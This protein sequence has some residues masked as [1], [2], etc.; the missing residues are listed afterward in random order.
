M[1]RFFLGNQVVSLLFLPLVIAGYLLLN[2]GVFGIET[3][4]FELTKFVDLGLWGRL[5][6]PDLQWMKWLSGCLVL[7]NAL[8]LNL[9][10]NNNAFYER[11]SYIVSL[12]YIVLMSFYHSFYQVDGVLIAHFW[13][14]LLL[15]QL[16]KMESNQD[17]RRIAFNAGLFF[18]LA[19][20]FHPPLIFAVPLLWIMLTRIRPFVFREILLS[21]AGFLVPMIYGFMV[22]FWNEKQINWNFIETAINYSQKQFIF[23]SFFVLFSISAVLS[24][25]GMRIKNS[26]SSIRFRKLTAIIFVFLLIGIALGTVEII[27]LKQYEWFS[28]SMLSLALFLPFS[29]F[30]KSTHVFATLLFYVTLIFS[31]TKFFI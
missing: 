30:Y 25:F 15:F 13:L 2:T 4:Y 28:F 10:F 22:V 7:I 19:A 16:F 5:E 24:I 1:I 29:F 6:L 12:L 21:T 14:I 26:K 31:I 18:G 11:N 20:S 23:L 9:L 8:T 27:F 17:G 3:M